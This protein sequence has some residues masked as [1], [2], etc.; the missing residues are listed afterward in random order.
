MERTVHRVR[1][2]TEGKGCTPGMVYNGRQNCKIFCP[3]KRRNMLRTESVS[4]CVNYRMTQNKSYSKSVIC[5][6]KPAIAL[7]AGIRDEN[8][9]SKSF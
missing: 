2:V 9:S 8:S 3:C 4:S 5:Q 1:S 7:Q 6:E